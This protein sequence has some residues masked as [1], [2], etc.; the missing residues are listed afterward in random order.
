MRKVHLSL[1]NRF[2]FLYIY[3]FIFR[4]TGIPD[5][6]RKVFQR[7]ANGDNMSPLMILNSCVVVAQRQT[8]EITPGGYWSIVR[9]VPLFP[10]RR[11]GPFPVSMATVPIQVC[12]HVPK[13]RERLRW[14]EMSRT[15]G[16]VVLSLLQLSFVELFSKW[17]GKLVGLIANAGSFYF[18]QNDLNWVQTSSLLPQKPFQVRR[19]YSVKLG[20]NSCPASK[21][22]SVSS[23]SIKFDD[24]M[25]LFG[26]VLFFLTFCSPTRLIYYSFLYVCRSP[27]VWHV[28]FWSVSQLFVTTR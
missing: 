18:Q 1:L 17:G 15:G 2:V 28:M 13:K 20:I 23:L 4:L 19:R 16:W 9:G 12:E 26:F 25:S 22:Q 6:K 21:A 11:P 27:H 10:P 7:A 8:E 14:D 24:F 3:I 5:R